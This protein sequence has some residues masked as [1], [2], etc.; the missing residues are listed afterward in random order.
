MKMV[1]ELQP[2]IGVMRNRYP[3]GSR[4]LHIRKPRQRV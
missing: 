1:M 4:I 2:V 3:S